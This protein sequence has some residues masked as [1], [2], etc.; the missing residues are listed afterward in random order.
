MQWPYLLPLDGRYSAGSN[1]ATLTDNHLPGRL[2]AGRLT[3]TQEIEVRILS[4]HPHGVRSSLGRASDC[5]SEGQGSNPAYTPKS[6]GTE[7]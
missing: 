4:R 3:L 6:S 7:Y 5:E 1:P 2:M